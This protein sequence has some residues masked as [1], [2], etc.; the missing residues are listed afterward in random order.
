MPRP[1]FPTARASRDFALGPFAATVVL[2]STLNVM[3]L[4]ATLTV[5][6]LA[7]TLVNEPLTVL[8]CASAGA[9]T[10]NTAHPSM[11]ISRFIN[12]SL[13]AFT[14]AGQ[15]RFGNCGVRGLKESLRR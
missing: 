15:E 11:A 1:G 4:P 10:T 3:S 2:A 12:P 13:R 9:A 5:I 8:V 7:P 14:L 6:V